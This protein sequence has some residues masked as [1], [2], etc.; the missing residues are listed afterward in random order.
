MLVE[1]CVAEGISS[2]AIGGE[3]LCP[4]RGNGVEYAMATRYGIG[5]R[6]TALQTPFWGRFFVRFARFLAAYMSKNEEIPA[7]AVKF[8][9]CG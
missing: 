4:C 6:R 8:S 3:G 9:F 2:S 5:S 7:A 1:L